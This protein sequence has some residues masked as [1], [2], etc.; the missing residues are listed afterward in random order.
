MKLTA[1][2]VILLVMV[3]KAQCQL[4]CYSC[5]DCEVMNHR[6]FKIETCDFDYERLII[7]DSLESQ[8]VVPETV[9]TDIVDTTDISTT[10]DMEL[11]TTTENLVSEVTTDLSTEVEEATT[12]DLSEQRA[13]R[14]SKPFSYCYKL[15]TSNGELYL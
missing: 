11:D 8:T 2:N 10:S 3:A 15:L 6:N 1:V 12:T 14:N 4:Q 7:A 13:K 5:D 9:T